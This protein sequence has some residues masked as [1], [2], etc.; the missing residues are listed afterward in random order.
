MT[1]AEK[2]KGGVVLTGLHR[3][4]LDHVAA[5]A[6]SAKWPTVNLTRATYALSQVM[7]GLGHAVEGATM[8]NKAKETLR[9]RLRDL[10]P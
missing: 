3:A 7:I 8:E 10:D 9:V 2:K 5:S 6:Q 1:I 4:N